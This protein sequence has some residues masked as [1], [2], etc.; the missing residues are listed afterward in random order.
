[1]SQSRSPRVQSRSNAKA[2]QATTAEEEVF[3][4]VTGCDGGNTKTKISYLSEEGNMVDLAIPTVIAKAATSTIEL[5]SALY[6]A[7][8]NPTENLH[9]M[10][11]SD[12]LTNDLHHSYFYVGASAYRQDE[13]I[14]QE[15]SGEE[16]HDSQLHLIVTLVG[17]ALA[18]AE[19]GETKARVNYHGGLPINEYKM[20]SQRL[21]KQLRGVHHITFVDGKHKGKTIEVDIYDGKI[22]AEGVSSVYGLIFTV[23]NGVL[24]HTPLYDQIKQDQSFIISDLGAETLDVAY[25]T[26]G[27]VSKHLSLSHDL[28]TNGYMDRLIEEI[29]L[30]PEFDARRQKNPDAR[31]SR[32]R[33]EFILRYL[34]KTTNERIKTGKDISYLASWGPTKNVD[35]TDQIID[36][37][38]EYGNEVVS[39]LDEYW[40]AKA[41][42]AERIYLVG[43]GT[44]FGYEVFKQAEGYDFLPD[45]IVFKSP[46]VTSRAYLI[47]NIISQQEATETEEVEA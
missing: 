41:S 9:V 37:V 24:K 36:Q 5:G 30:L 31:I 32:T 16:K 22:L 44:L 13:S 7:E 23:E 34:E 20:Y 14:P 42:D 29:S 6:D 1:M 10:L 4:L 39:F 2:P 46:F 27:G 21:M 25:Y 11:E 8:I 38:G 47:A 3:E 19:S 45:D 28:G 17:L 26:A 43:G 12:A 18:A 40:S 33:E 35:V 15:P